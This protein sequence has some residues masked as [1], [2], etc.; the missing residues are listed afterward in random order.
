[1]C[2]L[3][4]FSVET[5][6]FG[7]KKSV[8]WEVVPM[9]MLQAA[10]CTCYLSDPVLSIWAKHFMLAQVELPLSS[11]EQ[12]E[13]ERF[14]LI[15]HTKLTRVLDELKLSTDSRASVEFRRR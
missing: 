13:V 15:C 9:L 6:I 10:N 1:M 11:G 12:L 2:L 4:S 5:I 3:A 8:S 14:W 7:E